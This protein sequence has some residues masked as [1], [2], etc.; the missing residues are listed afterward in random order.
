MSTSRPSFRSS[1]FA[2]ATPA[3]LGLSAQSL[4]LL[5]LTLSISGGPAAR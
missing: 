3:P 2:A 5:A 4:A 1:G